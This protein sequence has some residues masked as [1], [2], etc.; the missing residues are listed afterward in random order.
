LPKDLVSEENVD[1]ILGKRVK[2]VKKLNLFLQLP[3][4]QYGEVIKEFEATFVDIA[5]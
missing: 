1:E 4:E 2:I 5:D 3:D